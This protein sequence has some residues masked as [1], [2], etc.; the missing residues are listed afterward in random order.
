MAVLESAW[1]LVPLAIYTIAVRWITLR[2]DRAL[3]KSYRRLPYKL[4]WPVTSSRRY[5]LW[6][7]P[8]LGGVTVIA[9]IVIDIRFALAGEHVLDLPGRMLPVAWLTTL[10]L[11]AQMALL[12]HIRRWVRREQARRADQRRA[13]RERLR[14]DAGPAT[15][16]AT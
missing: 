4:C 7:L 8:V 12:A 3:P 11:I 9:C 16:P 14:T 1:L 2:A 15:P 10:F 13:R 6:W 5:A